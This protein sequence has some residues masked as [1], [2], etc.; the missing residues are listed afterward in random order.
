MQ[1]FFLLYFFWWLP[2]KYMQAQLNINPLSNKIDDI[3]LD[4]NPDFALT[5]GGPT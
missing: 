3:D 5:K 2:R 4:D 1:I